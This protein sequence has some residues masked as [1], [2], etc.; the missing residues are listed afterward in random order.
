ME[1]SIGKLGEKLTEATLKKMEALRQKIWQ[2]LRDKPQAEN[3]IKAVQNGSEAELGQIIQAL[4]AEMAAD[5]QFA[6]E[7]HQ[8]AQQIINIESIDGR[9]IQNIYGGQGLQVN[10]PNQPVFQ[11]QGNPTIHFGAQSKPD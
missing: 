5:P 11:I 8:L 2:K 1:G 3:A 6:Q 7:V 4:Q 10:D 9:N